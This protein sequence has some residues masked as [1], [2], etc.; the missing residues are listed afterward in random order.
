[1]NPAPTNSTDRLGCGQPFE[2]PGDGVLTVDG[3]FPSTASGTDRA[4]TGT[5]EVT[6]RRAVRGVVSP[7]AEVFLVRQGAVA[8]VPT[9]QDLIG[10]QW[11]LAAGD[12]ERLPGDVPLVSCE[13]AGG[14]VPAG[15]YELYAR[16]VIVPD[17]GTDRLVSFGGPWPLRVT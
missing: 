9:A 13:P 11:D 7:G 5:V 8:A 2:T 16:V 14:P 15:D 10:V 6:S 4:V 12:V 17:G 1:M 3:R